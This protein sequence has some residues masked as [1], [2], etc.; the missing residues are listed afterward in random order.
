MAGLG[1]R[2]RV[3]DRKVGSARPKPLSRPGF[4]EESAHC[5]KDV[6]GYIR[7]GIGWTSALARRASINMRTG[8][9]PDEFRTAGARRDGDSGRA[10]VGRPHPRW[11]GSTG[12]TPYNRRS[13]GDWCIGNTAVSK[14]ATRGSTPRFPAAAPHRCFWA[15]ASPRAAAPSAAWTYAASSHPTSSRGV[16][17]TES[18]PRSL[19]LRAGQQRDLSAASAGRRWAEGSSANLHKTDQQSLQ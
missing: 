18:R 6:P 2:S 9:P 3:S 4:V 12:A 7:F 1:E 17:A 5:Y 16:V 14:T 10:C 11:A 15:C 13:P 8:A 19:W